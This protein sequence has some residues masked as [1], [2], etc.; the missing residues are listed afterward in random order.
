MEI[1]KLTTSFGIVRL[2][3]ELRNN[4]MAAVEAVI[5]HLMKQRPLGYELFQ[6]TTARLILAR[7]KNDRDAF[8]LALETWLKGL[9][10]TPQN[11]DD[12]VLEESS[13]QDW[14][15]DV[16][17]KKLK[18]RT[19][20]KRKMSDDDLAFI[21]DATNIPL[22]AVSENLE[23]LREMKI[24]ETPEQIAQ[25]YEMDSFNRH[26]REVS[27]ESNKGFPGITV[28]LDENGNFVGSFLGH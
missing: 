7:C 1:S 28:A 15:A 18:V 17:P 3:V 16:D 11:W 23:W 20:R 10:K 6:L 27:L 25:T 14:L 8:M 13:F 24:T 21:K 22:K 4:H 9:K 5:N 19:L 26:L 2:C 12:R